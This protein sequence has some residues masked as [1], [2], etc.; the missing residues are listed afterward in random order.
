MDDIFSK[1]PA[2]SLSCIHLGSLICRNLTAFLQSLEVSSALCRSGSPFSLLKL[3]GVGDSP[4]GLVKMRILINGFGAEPEIRHIKFQ[5][6]A[7]AGHIEWQGLE[8]LAANSFSAR[9][10]TVSESRTQTAVLG[11]SRANLKNQILETAHRLRW[12]RPPRWSRP[13]EALVGPN[14]PFCSRECRIT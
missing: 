1:F 12:P 5:E 6:E 10:T 14:W 11:R 8:L 9:A 3:E 7:D 13:R 2:M 4:G